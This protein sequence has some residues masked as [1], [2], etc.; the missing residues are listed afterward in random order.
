MAAESGRCMA[1]HFGPGSAEKLSTPAHLRVCLAREGAA[2]MVRIAKR[3]G[4]P[5]AHPIA[6]MAGWQRR[7]TITPAQL[8]VTPAQAGAQ[9]REQQ[10]ERSNPLHARAF[11]I[12]R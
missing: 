2:L 8:A 7:F 6:L 1:V 4:P 3:R 12:V 9:S 11:S 10:P 5:L